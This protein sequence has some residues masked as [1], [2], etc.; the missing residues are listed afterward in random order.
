LPRYF[1]KSSQDR[2]FQRP[3]RRSYVITWRQDFGQGIPTATQMSGC[4]S[5]EEKMGGISARSK[6]TKRR[7]CITSPN[8][9]R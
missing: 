3:S 1:W 7:Y 9:E 5:R 2:S 4:G 8:D 6:I